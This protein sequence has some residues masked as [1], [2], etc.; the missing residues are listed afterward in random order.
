MCFFEKIGHG[1]SKGKDIDIKY[2]EGREA[3]TKI[4]GHGCSSKKGIGITY[5]REKRGRTEQKRFAIQSR[6]SIIH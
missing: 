6:N 5:E 4:K 1:D 2:V 3:R